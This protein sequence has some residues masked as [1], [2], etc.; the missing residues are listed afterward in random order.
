LIESALTA[1]ATSTAPEKAAVSPGR[2]A[3]SPPSRLKIRLPPACRHR[4]E[5]QK[6]RGPI[7]ASSA[8]IS[9]SAASSIT[10][11]AMI[12]VGAIVRKEPR[13]AS[14]SAAI[15]AITTRPEEAIVSPTRCTDSPTACLDSSPARMRSR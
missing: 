7:S 14:K 11:I 2:R 3:I 12:S 1:R 6:T 15:A 5:G 4:F 10:A 9:V 13:W 8:G